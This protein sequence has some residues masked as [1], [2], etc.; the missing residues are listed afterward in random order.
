MI[1][2]TSCCHLLVSG[3]DEEYDCLERCHLS[4]DRKGLVCLDCCHFLVFGERTWNMTVL[5]AVIF[6]VFGEDEEYDCLDWCHL[7]GIRK[8][9]GI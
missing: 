1:A 6:L 3:E 2:L 8:G 4:V 5:T 7:S 9:R